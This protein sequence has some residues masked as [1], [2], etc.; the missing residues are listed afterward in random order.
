MGFLRSCADWDEVCAP[1]RLTI[2]KN[3]A[4]THTNPLR[5]PKSSLGRTSHPWSPGW[6]YQLGVVGVDVLYPEMTPTRA[7]LLPRGV[8]NLIQVSVDAV[9]LD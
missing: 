1:G 4:T 8:H 2:F 3:D 7:N 5:D 6:P 9:T